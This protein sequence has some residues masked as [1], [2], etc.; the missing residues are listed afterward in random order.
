M[1]IV[2]ATTLALASAV[3]YSSP[4]PANTLSKRGNNQCGASTF[5]D[6]GS[7]DSPW[8][9]DCQDLVATMD[10]DGSWQIMDW[11][12]AT[13]QSSGTCHFDIKA[14]E[15]VAIGSQDV[16]DLINDSI[17][18]FGRA[19]GRVGSMGLVDCQSVALS[20]ALSSA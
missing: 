9:T 15:G 7:F 20:W 14:H 18:K 8:I 1:L 4:S 6:V 17:A 2:F 10:P 5:A 11:T 13:T 19:G 12:K 16:S 3:P